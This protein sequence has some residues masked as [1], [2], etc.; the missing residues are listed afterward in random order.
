MDDHVRWF[1]C[2]REN[3]ADGVRGLKDAKD[4]HFVCGGDGAVAN[5]VFHLVQPPDA[6]AP[7]ART[8][9]RLMVSSEQ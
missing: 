8:Q 7:L 4:W 6:A 9:A 2:H 1:D 5:T 3:Q